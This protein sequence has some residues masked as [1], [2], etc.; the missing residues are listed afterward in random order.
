MNNKE[1]RLYAKGKEVT[2]WE[3]AKAINVSEPTM[4]RWFREEFPEEQKKA[5]IRVIDAISKK[6]K[7]NFDIKELRPEWVREKTGR[8]SKAE[9][10]ELALNYGGAR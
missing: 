4:T 3:I 5:Y 2:F 10:E 1:I 6:E 7:P 9:L 8:P